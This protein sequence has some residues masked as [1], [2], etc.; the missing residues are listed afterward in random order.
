M[1]HR[2][3]TQ[4]ITLDSQETRSPSHAQISSL[5]QQGLFLR[6]EKKT[7]ESSVL[8]GHTLLK[9]PAAVEGFFEQHAAIEASGQATVALLLG[10]LTISNSNTPLVCIL[11]LMKTI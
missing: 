6:D 11:Q 2:F 1:T 10:Y 7:R 9:L 8:W 3:Q 4:T 5:T